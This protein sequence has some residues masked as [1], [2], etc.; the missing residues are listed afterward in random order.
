MDSDTRETKGRRDRDSLFPA[1]PSNDPKW[2]SLEEALAITERIDVARSQ[3]LPY[4]LTSDQ[5]LDQ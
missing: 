5:L 1:S 2:A 3:L 4:V